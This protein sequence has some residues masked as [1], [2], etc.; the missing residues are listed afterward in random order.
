MKIR[1]Y[2]PRSGAS[3]A[4]RAGFYESPRDLPAV[5]ELLTLE[6]V[7]VKDGILTIDGAAML[8]RQWILQPPF[9]GF[10]IFPEDRFRD[11]FEPL[12]LQMDLFPGREMPVGGS[13]DRQKE[14]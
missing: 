2:I 10:R 1:T 9:A 4:F 3:T 11:L 12:E 13:S 14:R 5:K 6:D 7:E 8:E